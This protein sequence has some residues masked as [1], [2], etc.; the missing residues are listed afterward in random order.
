MRSTCRRRWERAVAE[1]L[2][3]GSAHP[4]RSAPASGFVLACALLA[5]AGF[6]ATASVA[7]AAGTHVV[8]IEGMR[9]IPQTLTVHRGDRVE[10]VNR[11]LVP[12][13]ASATSDAFDSGSIAPGARWRYV[14]SKRG[15]YPYQCQLHPTMRAT[16]IVR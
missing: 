12:H 2:R 14:A 3:A 7:A 9:F 11:D 6:A 5:G 16:L 4:R 15:D 13:T 8:V 10:W 1:C